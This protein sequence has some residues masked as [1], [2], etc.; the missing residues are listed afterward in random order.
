[1]IKQ[2]QN[3]AQPPMNADTRRYVFVG[4]ARREIFQRFASIDVH[5]RLLEIF[6]MGFMSLGA[7]AITR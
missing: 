5:R 3:S 1:M 4:A 2:S 7:R 6:E